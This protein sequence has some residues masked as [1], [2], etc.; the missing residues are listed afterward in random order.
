MFPGQKTDYLGHAY[1]FLLSTFK[2]VTVTVD[3]KIPQIVNILIQIRVD[4]WIMS[5]SKN[6]V[7]IKNL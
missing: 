3:L 7:A 4:V 5:G 2:S 1:T 6:G